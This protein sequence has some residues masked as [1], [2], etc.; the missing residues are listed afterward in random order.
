VRRSALSSELVRSLARQ[1]KMPGLVRS[2]DALARQA[3]KE[4]WTHGEFLQEVLS[5]EVA[6]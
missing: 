3:T 2:Y 1:L 4:H 5:A 6:S